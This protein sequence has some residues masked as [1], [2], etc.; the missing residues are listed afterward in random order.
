VLFD[1]LHLIFLLRDARTLGNFNKLLG[2][3]LIEIYQQISHD[4]SHQTIPQIFTEKNSTFKLNLGVK[5]Y[6]AYKSLAIAY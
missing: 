3:F 2:D 1:V 6:C 4:K 5:F